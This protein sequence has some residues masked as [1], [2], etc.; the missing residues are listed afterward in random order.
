[1]AASVIA[2][3]GL[4]F[5]YG[6]RAFR[7][8]VPELIAG[9]AESLALT[10]PSGC[11]KTTLIH[12][13]AGILEP[14][15]GQIEIVGLDMATLTPE[16]RQDLRILRIGLVFQEFELLDYLDV[17]DNVLLPYRLTPVLEL[18]PEVRNRALTLL[19]E[20]GLADKLRREPGRLSQGERQRVA[21]CRA[22]VTEPAVV[23]GDEP[24]GNLDPVNRDHV[25]DRL[26]AYGR[27]TGA[28]VVV[29]THDH[30]LLDRFDRRVEVET[31]ACAP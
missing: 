10:G 30:E 11:G 21:V 28:P 26:L 3:H 13:L 7:L 12:L 16:D 22:L 29:V 24:T 2:V 25:M 31:F 1:V 27:E 8:E 20:V 6:T 14:A 19:E 4:R 5:E 23:L 18:T 15:A 9:G 17:L